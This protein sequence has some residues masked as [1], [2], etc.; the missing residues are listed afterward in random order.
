M[1]AIQREVETKRSLHVAKYPVGLHMLVKGF[2]RVCLDQLVEDFERLCQMNEG[3][4]EKVQII[5][6][7]GM[8]GVGKTTLAKELFNRKCSQYE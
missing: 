2:E 7:F 4:K 5:D 3:N 8:G 1:S 6:I